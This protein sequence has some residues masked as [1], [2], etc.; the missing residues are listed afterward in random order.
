MIIK[1]GSDIIIERQVRQNNDYGRLVVSI[2]V[3][4][5]EL[6]YTWVHLVNMKGI[7]ELIDKVSITFGMRNMD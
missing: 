1:R 3:W 4:L 7:N 5:D 6:R 2:N